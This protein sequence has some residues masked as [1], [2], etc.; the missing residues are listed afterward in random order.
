MNRGW[1]LTA[2]WLGSFALLSLPG[3]GPGQEREIVTRLPAATLE[4]VLEDLGVK[5]QRKAQQDRTGREIPGLFL[6]YFKRAGR[7]LAL[8]YYD[9]KELM[10]QHRRAKLPLEKVNGWNVEAHFSRAYNLGNSSLVEWNLDCLGGVTRDSVKQFVRRFDEELN[11][12][13]KFVSGDPGKGLPKFDPLPN[14]NSNPNQG[15]VGQ[16]FRLPVAFLGP[17]QRQLE[18]TFPLGQKNWQ[19]AWKLEWQIDRRPV[20]QHLRSGTTRIKE[21]VYFG[22]KQ[23]WFR[24]GPSERD[25][26]IQV[27]HDARVSELFV[28]YNDGVIRWYD[29]LDHGHLWQIRPENERAEAGPRGQVLGK[30]RFVVGEVRDRGLLYKNID[31]RARRGETF[32]LWGNLNA[33]NYNYL[34]E[35]GFQDD[36][37]ITFRLG[38]TGQN[39]HLGAKSRHDYPRMGHMHNAQ[40]RLGVRLGPEG[41]QANTAYLVRHVEKSERDGLADQVASLFNDGLEGPAK[42]VAEEFTRVRVENPQVTM[43]RNRQPIAYE[44]VPSRQGS[45]RHHG[46]KR[47]SEAFTLHDFWVTREDSNQFYYTEL[48]GY[49][50]RLKKAQQQPGKVTNTSLVL[51]YTSSVLHEPRAEDGISPD[52]RADP[53]G[54]ALVAWSGFELRPRNV[55]T[56][57]PLFTPL[58]RKTKRP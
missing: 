41:E 30:E 20:P 11:L 47:R 57:T 12:F 26:W 55:F 14:P 32:V 46:T 49:F 56:G 22:I 18:V 17:D 36:G 25:P 6:Y 31:G 37:T 48:P 43:G 9:G 8:F 50:Q 16:P 34:I 40:W 27:L 19:T 28:P 10:L 24:A 35:Y 39:L 15:G 29:V 1:L 7:D 53:L 38:A 51:W 44:L 23:A 5:Y 21:N 33:G 42:W 52:H 54:P 2:G 3:P 13:E 58:P 4:K 45:S